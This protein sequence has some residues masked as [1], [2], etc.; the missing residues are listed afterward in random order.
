MLPSF[1]MR[2]MLDTVT[3]NRI[4]ELLIVP[5][6]LIRMVRDPIVDNYDLRCV[7]RFSTGAAPVSQEILGLLKKKF[8]WT[9]FKQAYGMTESCSCITTST[10]DKYLYELA[11]MVGDICASTSIKII[12]DDGRELGA[13]EPGE[14]LAKGP[15]IVMGYLGNE[16]ATKST[17]D[18]EG[19]LHTGDQAVVDKSGMVMITDRIKEM[20]KVKGI[21]VAPAELEDLL[22][23]HAAVEDVAV[24]GIADDYSGEKPKAYIVK[25]GGIEIDDKR[26]EQ[27]LIN[28]V[29]EKKTR[30]KWLKEVEFVSVIPKSA[31]GKILRRILRDKSK[32]VKR[33]VTIVID[34]EIKAKL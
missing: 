21:G 24:L 29:K 17:F 31:S 3:E 18:E 25:K 23:G 22:L 1:T 13:G 20:I 30:H 28:Y 4:A 10:P 8:P 6:I 5:P 14:L 34:G 16:E 15:Q 33:E 7:E 26:L 32:L 11:H 2:S 19:Y 12:G 9:G 27:E